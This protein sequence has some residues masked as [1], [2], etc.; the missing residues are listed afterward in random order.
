MIQRLALILFF[1]LAFAGLNVAQAPADDADALRTIKHDGATLSYWLSGAEDAPVLVFT[2]GATMNHGMFAAQVAYFSENYRTLT[3]DVRGHGLSGPID[4]T[5]TMEQAAEDLIAIL[6]GENIEQAVFIG[7][8]MGGYIIQYLY[9]AYP[10]RVQ[11]MIVIGST[12]I[13]ATYSQLE[14]TLLAASLPL[15]ETM[16]FELFKDLTARTTAITDNARE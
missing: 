4:D 2:H 16:P 8:S 11:A 1:M 13:A 14:I 5:F 10:E 6:D 15:I 7:Q 3:W 9:R 12:E